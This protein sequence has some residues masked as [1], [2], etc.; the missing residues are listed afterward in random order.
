MTPR[1]PTFE[2]IGQALAIDEDEAVTLREQGMDDPVP[3]FT[4]NVVDDFGRLIEADVG[5]GKWL[6]HADRQTG[7]P[8]MCPVVPLGKAEDA[9]YFLNTL[10]A[11]ESFKA[12]S[13]GKGPLGSIF[14]GRSRYLEW[15]WPRFG[16]A[17]KGGPPPVTG[18]DADDARQ[19]LQ[20]AC[21]YVGVF[22]DTEVVRGKGAWRDRDGSLIYHAGDKVLYRGRW[23]PPG[24]HGP[25]VFPARSPMARPWHT[26][27][28]G[29][30]HG[31]GA[32]LLA[33]YETWQWK[34]KDLDPR[35]LLGWTCM[36]MMAGALDWRPA[37]YLTGE[38]GCGKSALQGLMGVVLGKS[39]LKSVNT[40]GA[41]IYQKLKHDCTPVWVDE[42][43][44][45]SEN[46]MR[47]VVEIVELIRT[48]SSGGSINRGSS[49][50]I[51]RE[52]VCRSPFVCS[53]IN[54]PPMRGQDQSRFCILQLQPFPTLPEGE[55]PKDL[56]FDEAHIARIGRELLRRMIEGWPRWPA[57]LKAFRHALI[58]VGHDPR[59]A[60]QFGALL[61]AEHIA[62]S[63]EAPTQAALDA[64]AAGLAPSSLSETANKTEDWRECLQHMLDVAPEPLKHRKGGAN[65]IGGTIHIWR[66]KPDTGLVDMEEAC[67]AV[68]L[69]VSW[70]KRE[71]PSWENLRLFV[72]GSHPEVRKLFA[73]TT[74]AGLAGATGV[75]ANT[76]QRADVGIVYPGSCGRGL[77][78][79][80]WG[81][82]INLSAAFP[83]L[84]AGQDD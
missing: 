70:P 62:M 32:E 8:P 79:K 59:G 60:D 80:R 20:D 71:A 42:L 82:F 15:A 1:K 45:Q 47:K 36:A 48:A 2:A 64:C 33:L 54:I 13:S 76:L 16:K 27:V 38:K 83:A 28:E 29:G 39:L 34:R 44:A 57:T 84:E 30:A 5:P 67:T 35:L 14:A 12:S 19:A 73:G 7:L 11:I 75:W 3:G 56:E 58:K 21:A 23:L 49:E 52:Y 78:K 77:D 31:P 53:S 46:N 55:E 50:G 18:W 74:W 22:D 61:A 10:G 41:G 6:E 69:A 37:V 4:M 72:P 26:P 17:T 63:D 68:G 24:R 65:T 66:S 43:E 51:S 9:Y 25:W 81:V 40:S